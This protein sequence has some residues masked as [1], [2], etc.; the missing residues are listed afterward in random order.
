MS[1]KVLRRV[2]AGAGSVALAGGMV[3]TVGA[4]F[5]AAAPIAS[6][7]TWSDGN[8]QFTRT[9]DNATPHVGDTITISTAFQR[10]WSVEDIY[11]YKDLH[12]GCL[13]YVPGSAKWEGGAIAKVTETPAAPG[14]QASVTVD[15]PNLT[16][17]AVPGLGGSWGAKRTISMQFVVQPTCQLGTDLMT[18]MHYGGG[19]GSGVYQDKGPTINASKSASTTA[20][21][22]VQN[23]QVGQASTLSATVTGGR[24]GDPVD[25]YDAGTK[26]GSGALD[27]SGKA[28]FQWTPTVKG[29]H[30]LQAKFPDTGYATGSQSAVQNVNATQ[31][32]VNSTVAVGAVAG[33]QVGKA[34]TLAATVTPAGAGGTVTFKDG[35][36]TIASAPVGADG[37]ASYNWTPATAGDHAITAEFSGRDGVNA[38]TG[39]PVTVAVADK[40]AESTPSTT[41]L[42]GLSGA[43]VGKATTVSAKVSPANAGGTVT[44]KDGDTVIGTGQVGADGTASTNWTPATSGQRTLT[45]EFSG[46]GTVTSS[47]DQVSVSVAPGTGGGTPGTPGTG[48]GTGSLSNLLGGFGS[49]K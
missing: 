37:K 33:A 19:L 39:G 14:S 32:N 3:A 23:V 10:K 28:S 34:S 11:N 27:G 15:S 35:A 4:G 31:A 38:S 29:A 20:L 2:V 7:T 24:S 47:S 18:T 44:F 26:I 22:A 17:W 45:A 49:S 16:S 43:Q 48:G 1:K 46:N 42:N 9:I 13:S 21:A 40:P 25:F 36:A 41:T 12:D 5:A 6:P 30:S 8:S